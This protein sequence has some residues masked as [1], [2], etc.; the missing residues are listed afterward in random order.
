MHGKIVTISMLSKYLKTPKLNKNE[1]MS[2][3]FKG[4]LY[5]QTGM[6]LNQ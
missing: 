3:L 4:E 2:R 1:L 5:V 6:K